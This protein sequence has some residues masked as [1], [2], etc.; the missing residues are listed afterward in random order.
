MALD[1]N[2]KSL[3][4]EDMNGNKLVVDNS[5]VLAQG[6]AGKVAVGSTVSV[7]DGALEVS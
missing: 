1:D 3:R 4:F 6:S 5:G 2:A 7:N